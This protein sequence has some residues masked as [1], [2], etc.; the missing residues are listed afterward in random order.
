MYKH[1]I[2]FIFALFL[3]FNTVDASN[4][5][6]D[7]I[8]DPAYVI[9]LDKSFYVNGEMIWYKLHLPTDAQHQGVAIKVVLSDRSGT[10]LFH[11]FLKN[12]EASYVAGY[13][14]IPFDLP[15]GVYR[16]SFLG[17]EL[18]TGKIHTLA[19][20][21]LPIYNDS[22]KVAT[23]NSPRASVA[24]S[25]AANLPANELKVQIELSADTLRSR[26]QMQTTITVRDAN[27][28]V[29]D[30]NI[31]LAVGD[32]QLTSLGQNTLPTIIPGLQA[33]IAT[34]LDTNIFIKA[35][36]TNYNNQVLNANVLGVLAPQQDRIYYTRTSAPG[37]VNLRLPD[38]YA[39][40]PIQF[41]GFTQEEDSIQVQIMPD[42]TLAAEG[43]LAYTPEVL[44][45]LEWSRKRKK[46]F[47]LYT[48]LEFN[49]QTSTPPVNAQ[50]L[51]P[52]RSIQVKDYESFDNVYLF[53]KEILT[54]LVF[55]EVKGE[56]EVFEAK[57]FTD[58]GDRR[59]E[60]LSGNP[61]FIIDGQ[62]T[63]AGN[64]VA[65]MKMDMVET[66]DIFVD[67][68]EL[69]Q[70]FNVLGTSGVVIMKTSSSDITVPEQDADDIKVVQG[71]QAPASFPAF[72]QEQFQESSHRPFFRPQLYWNPDLKTNTNGQANA[73]FYQSDATGNFQIRVVVQ[74]KSGRIGY[75]EK[76]YYAEW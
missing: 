16:L 75:A 7:G 35:R 30:A 54:P 42:E 44:N 48:D 37:Q 14:K 12:R 74:D 25:S 13:Y 58:L 38:F 43:K 69:R 49:L 17:S 52:A 76:T 60:M 10:A 3:G 27:G 71:L 47:Q 1:Y 46:M 62:A 26:N 51:K 40:Q 57:V 66:V 73:S 24:Q 9:H 39:Q 70:Q 68:A 50:E 11:T 67:R 8:A 29:V 31:S 53:F 32:Q 4:V 72:S 56:T 45:Y 21:N 55:R 28:Q 6:D 15:S 65:H 2:T 34:Q 61:L 23:E 20:V 63:R 41:L 59:Y 22:E 64:Y 18:N 33:P 5:T 19:K 36:L